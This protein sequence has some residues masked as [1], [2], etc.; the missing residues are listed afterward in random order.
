MF[1]IQ[2]IL[3]CDTY[4]PARRAAALVLSDLL[5]GMSNLEEF[6]DFLLPIYRTLKHIKD[7]DSDLHVQIHATNGLECLKN[8]IKEALSKEIKIEKE[9]SICDVRNNEN[10]IRYK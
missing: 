5:R 4:L 7:N 3:Q 1:L 2:N 8:K 6:Q 10:S 9:I